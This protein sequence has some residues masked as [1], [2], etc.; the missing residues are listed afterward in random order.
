M[1]LIAIGCSEVLHE[2]PKPRGFLRSTNTVDIRRGTPSSGQYRFFEM[3]QGHRAAEVQE[4]ANLYMPPM[5]GSPSV[6]TIP[7]PTR[8]SRCASTE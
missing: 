4:L 1:T 7:R 5:T 3:P 8:S 6:V 2:C